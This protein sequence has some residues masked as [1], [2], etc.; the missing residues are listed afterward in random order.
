MGTILTAVS[1]AIW[2]PVIIII[3]LG[4][5]IFYRSRYKTATANQALVIS[6]GKKQK[7][8]ILVSGGAIVPP[9][10]KYDM[11][12]IKVM[13]ITGEQKE[14]QTSTMVKV[15]VE[16][17]AQV[18]PIIHEPDKLVTAITGFLGLNE[19]G[20]INALR[21]TLDAK[22]R[23]IVATMTPEEVVKNRDELKKRVTESA[24]VAM[25]EFG[26]RLIDLSPNDV[27]DS[28]DHYL[29]LAA[30]DREEK[31]REAANLTATENK[32]IAEVA[33][34]TEKASE[35]ARIAKD[36]AVAEME[37]DLALKKAGYREET[38]TAQMS[39]EYAGRLEEEKQ[40]KGVAE[41]QRQVVMTEAETEKQR[42]Q[43]DAEAAKKKYEINAEAQASVA[44]TV[45]AGEAQ[46]TVERAEGSASAIKI[47]ADAEAQRIQ[48]TGEAEAAVI[49]AKRN[50]EA[51]GILAEGNAR[52]EAEKAL[53]EAR[54]ANEEVNLRVTLAE[55]E[56]RTRIEIATAIGNAVGEVG[57]KA[58]FIDM[59]GGKEG[60]G[61]LLT[62]VLGN[63]P[64]MMAKMDVQS[65]V[66]KGKSAAEVINELV[67]A[68]FKPSA[69]APAAATGAAVADLIGNRSGEE[70]KDAD[71]GIDGYAAGAAGAAGTA[72]AAGTAGAAGGTA[73]DAAAE[74]AAAVAAKVAEE[75]AAA[76]AAK[77]AE[78]KAAA[79]AAE[80]AAKKASA[81]AT[82]APDPGP[83]SGYY[84]SD[85]AMAA[86][87]GL[88]QAAMGE[89]PPA[90]KPRRLDNN[91]PGHA[92]DGSPDDPVFEEIREK[93]ATVADD[94]VGDMTDEIAEIYADIKNSSEFKNED[95]EEC[96]D[97]ISDVVKALIASDTDIKPKEIAK[98]IIFQRS[99]G[100]DNTD[101]IA[102]KARNLI[103]T[104][105]NVA[106]K[107][108]G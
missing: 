100:N 9:F 98:A 95:I 84:N 35:S 50:A 7:P 86:A 80:V 56:S 99:T 19:Q 106:A 97:M 39:A 32:T 105:R 83:D 23:E 40:K 48:R 2:I 63:I 90:K 91:K 36:L 3:A 58:T 1:A 61:D 88:D 10:Y 41:A 31:R 12:P 26:F 62:N 25:L 68:I 93:V 104:A 60:G 103:K 6:G 87:S 59:G 108:K 73:A 37:R 43:I 42:V 52:A 4:V 89:R 27:K 101:M 34:Q 20:I 8:R 55:I 46:A 29:H 65:Q 67:S 79:V 30:K 107:K 47:E 13:T 96:V 72:K 71:A 44:K 22:V 33:A 94:S 49:R 15:V 51:S 92:A 28:N 74:R 76:V 53:A 69:A 64:G 77:V 82:F 45:A 78:E 5:L 102:E 75:K 16:W 54:S 18:Q 85:A 17:T 11:F 14:T 66:L 57:Q 38:E 21:P 81:T 70:T 24:A